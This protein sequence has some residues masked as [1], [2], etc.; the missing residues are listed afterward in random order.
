MIRFF[1][2]TRIPKLALHLFKTKTFFIAYH[3]VIRNTDELKTSITVSESEFRQ[4]MAFLKNNFECISIEEALVEDNRARHRPAVV[5]TFDDGY[6]NNFEVARPI[7]NEFQ[8]PAII[9]ITT[10]HV[11]Q[12]ELFWWDIIA[13]AAKRSDVKSVDLRGL[14]NSLG[15]YNLDGS[16]HQSQKAVMQICDDV[17][18]ADPQAGKELIES[19][20]TRFRVSAGAREFQIETENNEVTPLTPEQIS[21]LASEPLITIGSHSHCHSLLHRVPL[22]QAQESIL[23]SKRAL[24]R[25]TNTTVEHFSYPNGYFSESLTMLLRESGFR[26]AVTAQPGCFKI[27]YN[28]LRIKRSLVGKDVSTPLFKAMLMTLYK[29]G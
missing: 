4:H 5:V 8:I 9:Y 7:L 1:N 18:K 26:S 17:K 13:I 10:R 27:G 6:A 19:I 22:D 21:L 23:T 15:Y 12:R 29:I 2:K 24:E 11:F 25:I 20:V 3:G 16:T 14:A 28:P